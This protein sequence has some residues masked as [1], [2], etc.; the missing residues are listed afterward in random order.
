MD[1]K[2]IP[3]R[4]ALPERRVSLAR[5]GHRDLKAH[6]VHRGRR[7]PIG[8][9]GVEGAIGPPRPTGPNRTTGQLRPS[10]TDGRY[11]AH[12][13]QR[14]PGGGA[15]RRGPQGPEGPK[16]DPG[17][18]GATGPAGPQGPAGPVGDTGPQGP[19]GPSGG[20]GPQG[21]EGPKGATGATGPAG[22]QGPAGPVGR[23]RPPGA[24]GSPVAAAVRRGQ[25]A[26]REI[27][28]PGEKRETL[29][30]PAPEGS[31]LRC[32]RWMFQRR[33]TRWPPAATFPVPSLRSAEP[34][35]GVEILLRRSSR[36]PGHCSRQSAPGVMLAASKPT[37]ALSA[38]V[39]ALTR[40]Q[41]TLTSLLSAWATTMLAVSR[42]M[43]PWLAGEPAPTHRWL[44]P[45]TEQ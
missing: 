23:Y 3:A 28:A 39:A 26:I 6:R 4:P 13:D 25:R 18:T 31:L 10:R 11:R 21:T 43:E 40:R 45:A 17:A 12:R 14:V 27:P 5:Q 42:R 24:S 8:D 7:G 30:R 41:P 2:G 1:R 34:D 29:D 22:P 33:A 38:G 37:T 16:G 19:A 15:G 44:K 9:P 36:L 32:R 35:A 20:G